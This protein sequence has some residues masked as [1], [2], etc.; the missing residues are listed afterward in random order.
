[1]L[2]LSEGLKEIPAI[3]P[4]KIHPEAKHAFYVQ[5]FKF[6]SQRAGVHREKF[7][8]AVKA[9]LPLM[10]LREEEGVLIN[11]GYVRPLYLQ[12]LYQKRIAFGKNGYPFTLAGDHVSYD[13]GICPV[14]ERMYFDEI[15]TMDLCHPSMTQQ[16]LNDVITAFYKVWDGRN[17]LR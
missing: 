1:V 4:P 5:A 6:D 2:Y 8:D 17:S 10:E 16:D 12:S 3:T 15:F 13:K 9:E 14:V 11:C 7:I